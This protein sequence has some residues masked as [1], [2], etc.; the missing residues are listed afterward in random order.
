MRFY[1][2]ASPSHNVFNNYNNNCIQNKPQNNNVKKNIHQLNKINDI[3]QIKITNENSMKNSICELSIDNFTHLAVIGEKESINNI[4]QMK[5]FRK[6]NQD[7]NTLRNNLTANNTNR[8]SNHSK[9]NPNNINDDN[10]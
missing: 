1:K 8:F 2:R 3:N 5:N 7:P 6:A 4:I 9:R 10:L